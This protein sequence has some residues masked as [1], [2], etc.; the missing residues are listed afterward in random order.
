VILSKV[1]EREARWYYL[2]ATSKMGWSRNVLIH[3]IQSRAY[4][5]HWVA[6][7]QHNF[8]EA[9]PKHLAEQADEAMKD[10]YMLDILGAEEPILEA[11]LE[12]RIVAKIKQVMLELGYG[13]AFIAN[14]YPI[15][16]NDKAQLQRSCSEPPYNKILIFIMISYAQHAAQY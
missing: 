6:S 1:K 5:R 11:E 8:Q 13:F 12:A 15:Q 14:Q 16:A 3:Q 2:Q 7:K 4:E 10:V 9:L